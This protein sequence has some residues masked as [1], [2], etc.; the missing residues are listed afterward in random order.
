MGVINFTC[1]V[2]SSPAARQDS[3]RRLCTRAPE[4]SQLTV[5]ILQMIVNLG[6]LIKYTDLYFKARYQKNSKKLYWT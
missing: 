4:N 1:F 3:D 6:A 5:G 2:L